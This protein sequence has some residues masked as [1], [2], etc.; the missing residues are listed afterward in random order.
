[1]VAAPSQV[2]MSALS[3]DQPDAVVPRDGRRPLPSQVEVAV[4]QLQPGVQC[5]DAVKLGRRGKAGCHDGDLQPPAATGP[6]QGLAQVARTGADRGSRAITGEQ[7]SATTSVPR[8]LKLRTGF[9]VFQLDAHRA[10]PAGLQRLAA[11]QRSIEKNRVDHPASRPD[12]GRVQARLRHGSSLPPPLFHLGERPAARAV[13]GGVPAPAQRECR[14]R[15][16]P[17]TVRVSSPGQ[18]WQVRPR[19]VPWAPRPA[20]GSG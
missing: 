2:S 20:R 3:S 5:A 9:A 10:P 15:A 11:I 18:V 1:M 14:C 12:P 8:A 17:G 13:P 6:G 16:V 4:H 19:P 7:A